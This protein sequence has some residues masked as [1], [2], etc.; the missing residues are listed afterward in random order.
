MRI[1]AFAIYSKLLAKLL[2]AAAICLA[3]LVIPKCSKAIGDAWD[4]QDAGQ[5]AYIN[6]HKRE[7]KHSQAK[8]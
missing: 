5:A 6:D 2:I 4:R 7:L 1:R 8:E 3:F